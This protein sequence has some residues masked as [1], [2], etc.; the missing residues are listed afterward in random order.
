VNKLE[1]RTIISEEDIIH[2][3]E[4]ISISNKDQSSRKWARRREVKRDQ[5][6]VK[7][8]T[9]AG[10]NNRENDLAIDLDSW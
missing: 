6:L 9:R 1:I 4:S 3:R 5:A 8:K 10:I 2:T 7:E